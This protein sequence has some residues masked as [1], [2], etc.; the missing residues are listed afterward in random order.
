MHVEEVR[1]IEA[2]NAFSGGGTDH[3]GDIIPP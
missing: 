3:F 2:R 1:H